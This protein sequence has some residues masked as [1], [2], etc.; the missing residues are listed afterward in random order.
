MTVEFPQTDLELQTT[1]AG[2]LGWRDLAMDDGRL[3]GLL[4][5]EW[6]ARIRVPAWST[7]EQH[8]Y[9]I[10]LALTAKGLHD[11]YETNLI[12]ICEAAVLGELVP[13]ELLLAAATPRQRCEAAVRVLTEAASG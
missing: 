7:N 2:L 3:V 10:E 6:S 5:A 11:E 8:R 13:P 12:E 1:L 9:A 4:P